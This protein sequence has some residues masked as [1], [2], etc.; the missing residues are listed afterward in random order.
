[1]FGQFCD[2]TKEVFLCPM[3]NYKVSTLLI[4]YLR[5]IRWTQLG[6]INGTKQLHTTGQ[7]Y[8]MMSSRAAPEAGDV[9]DIYSC[10]T[11]FSATHYQTTSISK[12]I[13]MILNAIKELAM[14]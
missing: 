9:G 8:E 1:M 5:Q 12:S 2:K 10:M 6:S 11:R 13:V 14:R 3:N 7:A 4:N